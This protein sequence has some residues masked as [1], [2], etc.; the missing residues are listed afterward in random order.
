[1][2]VMFLVS[3]I[4]VASLMV[5]SA[6]ITG[7]AVRDLKTGDSLLK[8]FDGN[9]AVG[10]TATNA[11]GNQIKITNVKKSFFRGTRVDV[12]VTPAPI[13]ASLVG[14][15]PIGG[16]G[17]GA[18]GS[19]TVYPQHTHLIDYADT[20]LEYSNVNSAT[21]LSSPNGVNVYAELS[22]DALEGA[23][24]VS[25]GFNLDFKT[26]LS[27]DRLPVIQY[28][29]YVNKIYYIGFFDPDHVI[30]PQQSIAYVYCAQIELADFATTPHFPY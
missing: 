7:Y 20:N 23:V 1:M 5:V 2:S 11:E 14:K 27:T 4:L 29:Y 30:I 15:N 19:G 18:V 21:F 3:V 6:G 12:E 22:C 26:P 25:A 10:K 13:D 9:I 28:A 24:P 8:S 16:S 17:A